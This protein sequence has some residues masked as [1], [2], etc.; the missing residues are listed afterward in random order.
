MKRKTGWFF[1]LGLALIVSFYPSMVIGALHVAELVSPKQPDGS[2]VDVRVWGDEFYLRAESLDGYTVIRD[3]ETGWI[4]YADLAPDRS[5]FVSTGIIYR[6]GGAVQLANRNEQAIVLRLARHLKLPSEIRRQKVEATR[7]AL[8]IPDALEKGLVETEQTAGPAPLIGSVV[9]LTLLIQFPDESYTISQAEIDNYCN[10]VG[11]SNYSNN[12][13][14]RDYFYDVSNS[15]LTYTNYVSAY[16]TAQ[17]EK[18][19]YTDPEISYGTRARELVHE[20][21]VWLDPSFNSV[22]YTHLRA[23]ET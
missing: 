21:L 8:L 20:A 22:S 5:D 2:R 16:Y 12:G 18:D 3:P 7:E 23:H 4:C 1:F 14:V 10:Q 17:H 6:G 13:S 9:G 11:Y 19:Y 15:L